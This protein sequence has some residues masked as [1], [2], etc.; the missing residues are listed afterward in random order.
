MIAAN[1]ASSSSY[2]VRISALI[3]G[4]TARTVRQ[5]SMPGPVGQSRVEDG[6]VGAEGGDARRG[7]L[8]EPGLADDHDVAAGLQQR[9][10]AL[11]D[12]LVV[13]EQ[14]HPDGR[15]SVGHGVC[16]APCRAGR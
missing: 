5:T 8:G 15:G 14:E 6:D 7:L 12:D 4:S 10:Q 13:V 1:S 9:A 3:A 2:D 11:S 16:L